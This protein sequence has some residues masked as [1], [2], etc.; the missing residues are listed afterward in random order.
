MLKVARVFNPDIFP[1]N[2]QN[3]VFFSPN[4]PRDPGD[5]TPSAM[6]EAGRQEDL[7]DG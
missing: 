3:D 6:R 2:I 4:D 5:G 7:Q 1:K